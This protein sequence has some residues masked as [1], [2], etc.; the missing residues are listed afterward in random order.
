MAKKFTTEEFLEKSKTLH[1]DKYDYSKTVY[2]SIKD[3]VSI[4]CK[5]HGEFSQKA[6]KH[7]AGRGCIECGKLKQK[8]T[9]KRRYGAE[10][11]FSSDAIKLKIKTTM[12]NKYGGIGLH[13]PVIRHKVEKTNLKKYGYKNVF[14]DVRVQQKSN[15]TKFTKYND[16]N[17][18]NSKKTQETVF[19]RYGV[20]C[21]FNIKSIRQIAHKQCRDDIINSIFHGNRLSGMVSP[22]F[23]ESEY[24]NVSS[25]YKFE[26][27]TCKTLFFDTLDDGRIPR[28]PKCFPISTKSQPEYEIISF[29]KLHTNCE[30]FHGARNILSDGKELD[31]YIPDKKLAI[32]FNGLYWHS[33]LTGNKNKWYHLNKTLECEKLGIRLIHIFEDEWINNHDIVKSRILNAIGKSETIY[34]RECIVGVV[35]NKTAATFLSENHTQGKDTSSI[36]IGLYLHGTLVSIMTFG[37]LRVCM[38]TKSTIKNTYELYRFCGLKT[39]S[40]IGGASK[41]FKYFIK[42]Y[43]PESVISYSDRRMG[44][45]TVYETLNF[46]EVA[47]TS[48]NYWYLTADHNKRHHRFGFAKHKLNKKLLVFDVNLSE[49]ENMRNNGY[50]RI[51]DCGHLKYV[52]NKTH[53]DII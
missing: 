28:C 2:T 51:W 6:E 3:S 4:I 19:N 14:A 41:L 46:K 47:K 31:I 32:E 20:N 11:P 15:N 27:N 5:L 39:Y 25:Q 38:G 43:C 44:T 12:N 8:S 50:D 10:N 22:K 52:W 26:C 23:T 17:Y 48:P 42:T 30:I 29:L 53:T 49:W 34:A 35:D 24:I 7:L 36:R 37:K 33:E 16:K 13:S 40:V 9:C 1:N 18:N 21:V 45:G